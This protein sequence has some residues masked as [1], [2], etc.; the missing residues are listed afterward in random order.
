MTLEGVHLAKTYVIQKVEVTSTQ[1]FFVDL[2]PKVYSLY[3]MG[4]GDNLPTW[5]KDLNNVDIAMQFRFLMSTDI[6][7]RNRS[8]YN[9]LDL[10][11][12]VGGCLDALKYVGMF[13]VWLLSGDCL[14]NY[15]VSKIIKFDD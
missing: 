5:H 3:T 4:Q 13:L 8:V 9:L 14:S 11:G 7:Y 15:L 6:V 1:N 10:L 12:D 2:F